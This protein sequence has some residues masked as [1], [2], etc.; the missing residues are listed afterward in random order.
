MTS[1]T[2]T[3]HRCIKLT[4]FEH[5]CLRGVRTSRSAAPFWV[6]VALHAIDDRRAGLW[7]PTT[8]LGTA[9]QAAETCPE[10]VRAAM[11]RAA[12]SASRAAPP[13]NDEASE[14]RKNSPMK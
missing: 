4:F 10:L 8:Q 1:S 14:V 9:V 7:R 2:G 3:R 11:C 5:R 6:A 13:T 12:Y